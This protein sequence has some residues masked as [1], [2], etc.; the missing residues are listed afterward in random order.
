MKLGHA[1]GKLC[2]L[3]RNFGK[4]PLFSRECVWETSHGSGETAVFVEDLEGEGDSQLYLVTVHKT[5]MQKW[6][7]VGKGEQLHEDLRGVTWSV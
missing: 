5:Q 4:I 1:H 7:L 6:I 2:C 3:V